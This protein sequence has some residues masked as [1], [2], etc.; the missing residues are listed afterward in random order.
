M[1]ALSYTEVPDID[2]AVASLV[3][4]GFARTSDSV[5]SEGQAPVFASVQQIRAV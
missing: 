5:S 2:A 3:A 4:A 1:A